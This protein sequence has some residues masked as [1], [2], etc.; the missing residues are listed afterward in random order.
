MERLLTV[1]ILLGLVLNGCD[2]RNDGDPTGVLADSS[3]RLAALSEKLSLTFPEGTKLRS[4]REESGMDS[5]V[6]A[7]LEF[8]AQQWDEFLADSPFADEPFTDEKRYLLGPDNGWWDPKKPKLLPTAQAQLPGGKVLNL[9][10]DRGDQV[11]IVV[12][13]V[14]HE[15]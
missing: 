4:V 3:D 5:A 14:W 1:V 15:T 2:H 10:V 11:R 8:D 6:F 9:G 12:Y 7:K 13:L